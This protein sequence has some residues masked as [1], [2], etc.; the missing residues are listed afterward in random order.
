MLLTITQNSNNNNYPHLYLNS[1]SVFGNPRFSVRQDFVQR[2]SI[3]FHRTLYKSLK[4]TVL[5]YHPTFHHCF[6]ITFKHDQDYFIAA[7]SYTG[8][9]TA[10]V[11]RTQRL[12]MFHLSPLKAAGMKMKCSKIYSGRCPAHIEPYVKYLK[13]NPLEPRGQ[14][15][16][17]CELFKASSVGW[18]ADGPQAS[19]HKSTF[20][21]VSLKL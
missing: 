4:N 5:F 1:T 18:W 13:K 21:N 10:N 7:L 19:N 15:W 11:H 8:L 14:H 3:K 12:W 16:R 20:R 17:K 2:T 6:K 9:R